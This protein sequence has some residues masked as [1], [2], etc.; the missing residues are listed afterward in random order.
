MPRTPTVDP[1]GVKYLYE[2]CTTIVA[3]GRRVN[4]NRHCGSDKTSQIDFMDQQV[5]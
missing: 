5:L 3:E 2:P 4:N 1:V